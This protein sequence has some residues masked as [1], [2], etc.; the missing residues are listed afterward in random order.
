MGISARGGTGKRHKL[1]NLNKLEIE[2]GDIEAAKEA[3]KKRGGKV[4][5]QKSVGQQPEILGEVGSRWGA[6]PKLR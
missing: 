3:F 2:G 5:K 4:Q 6:L 1:K